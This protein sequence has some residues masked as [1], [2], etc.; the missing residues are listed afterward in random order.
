VLI[1]I[2]CSDDKT[3]QSSQ[4]SSSGFVDDKYSVSKTPKKMSTQEKKKRFREL[5]IPAVS[6]VYDKLDTQY[7]NVK[8]ILDEN[9]D[10]KKITKLMDEYDTNNTKELLL[11]IKPHPKSIAIAQAAMESAWATSRFTKVANNLFGVWSFNKNEPRV[12]ATQKRGDK[13]IYLKKYD[14]ITESVRDYYKVLSRGRAFSEF[15]ALNM[16]TDNP[17]ELVKKL[18][19]Y[20]EKGAKYGKELASMIRFNKFHKYDD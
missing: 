12:P 14:S 1:N 7:E 6:K 17:Y 19:K 15:R 18:D 8:K 2:G 10:S 4:S 11:R 13:T 16:K 5:L 9:P 3:D 20:S